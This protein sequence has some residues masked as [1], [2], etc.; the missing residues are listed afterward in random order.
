M[1]RTL[2]IGSVVDLSGFSA[3]TV[4]EG[5]SADAT[6]TDILSM[7]TSPASHI[8]TDNISDVLD[9]IKAL[10]LPI[11]AAGGVVVDSASNLLF[12]HRLGKWDLPKGKMEDGEQPLETALR[13]I[14]EET[15]VTG[16]QNHGKLPTSWHIYPLGDSWVLKETHWFLFSCGHDVMLKP[17]IEESIDQVEWISSADLS[18]PLT[19]TYENI[20]MVV[21]QALVSL[22]LFP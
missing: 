14:Q 20:R 18:R 15:G 3:K 9:R 8:Q 10:F 4:Y 21:Q 6:T 12:I 2:P 19:N 1:E 7:F 5:I 13:E 17:Q 16:L 11:Q 22:P